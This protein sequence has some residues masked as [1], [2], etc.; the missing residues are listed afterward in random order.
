VSQA[1]E[2]ANLARYPLL[3]RGKV[4]DV[5]DLGDNLLL[6]ATDRI[7]AFD[8]VL[9]SLLP[10]KGVVLTEISRFWFD[11]IGEIVSTQSTD[12]GLDQLELQTDEFE[13]LTGRSVVVRKAERIDIECV[14]RAYLA[15]SAWLEYQKT[16]SVAGNALPTGL[17]R[18]DS[19]PAILFTPAIKN[20]SGHD[21]NVSVERLRDLVGEDLAT[22]LEMTSRRIF[23]KGAEVAADAGFL[24]ADTKFEFGWIDGE[25][26]VIDEVL[27]PDSSRYWDSGDLVPGEEPAAYDKQPVRDWLESSGW[28]KEAPGPELPGDIIEQTLGRYRSVASRLHQSVSKGA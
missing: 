10:G 15:G 28:N 22:Q 1:I 19:L 11:L 13:Q 25:L 21:E 26:S 16:G 20:D 12:L 8:V 27:T 24:L 2:K 23:A 4:R 9:P 17:K 7:S 3:R 6:V 14:I 18:G 5:F